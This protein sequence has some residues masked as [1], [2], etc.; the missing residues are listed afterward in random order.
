L[1]LLNKN[2]KNLI[3]MKNELTQD[4]FLELALG[5]IEVAET[6][7][8]AYDSG[9]DSLIIPSRG[10]WPIWN[11]SA[12][13]LYE[14]SK[15]DTQYERFYESMRVPP[16]QRQHPTKGKT[17][18]RQFQVIPYPLTADVHIDEDTLKKYGVTL[19]EVT[20]SIRRYGA[21][22]ISTFMDEPQTRLKSEEFSFL[23]FLLEEVEKRDNVAKY[24]R[25]LER[26]KKPVILDT[27]ISGRAI[28]TITDTFD[29]LG[30]DYHAIVVVD[31]NGIKMRNPYK[32]KLENKE[33][34]GRATI[35][36][37]ERIISE[38]RGAALLGVIG[39]I[40]P[41]LALLGSEYIGKDLGAVSWHMIYDRK[42]FR[43]SFERLAQYKKVY[44]N[45]YKTIADGI[46]MLSRPTEN[47]GPKTRE[48]EEVMK[49]R[50][51]NILRLVEEYRILDYPD[52]HLDPGM[53]AP[54][55]PVEECWETSSHVIHIRFPRD[56]NEKLIREYMKSYRLK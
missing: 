50:I 44:R 56:V 43:A 5:C 39:V 20:D 14:L 16:F 26:I 25:N 7:K 38:D 48:R 23:H 11:G 41:E 31:R 32:T 27:A 24:Y 15:S 3:N 28:T 54:G 2:L 52:P 8:E 45:Y 1:K 37:V 19:D 9:H 47:T 6:L 49:K 29:D 35:I 10:A 12:K 33:K 4:N 17:K 34:E 46:K 42:N 21:K 40:Y 36:P 22:V 51:E 55:L 18:D 53:F 30:V 13:A